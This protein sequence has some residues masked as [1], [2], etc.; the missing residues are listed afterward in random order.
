MV[1]CTAVGCKEGSTQYTESVN[2]PLKREIMRLYIKMER[3][4]KQYLGTLEVLL[5]PTTEI[6]LLQIAKI[7]MIKE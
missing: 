3:I 7:M 2:C 5:Q 4:I 1:R 6:F